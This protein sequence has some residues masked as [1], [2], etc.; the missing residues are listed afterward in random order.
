MET[1][2][3]FKSF[4]GI[5]I[6]YEGVKACHVLPGDT[7]IF[8]PRI[9]C[10]FIYFEDKTQVW[11]SRRALRKKVN[12]INQKFIILNET[13]PKADAEIKATAVRM[14]LET[15]TN[16]CLVS[17]AVFGENGSKK[18]IKLNSLHDLNKLEPNAIKRKFVEDKK[19]RRGESYRVSPEGKKLYM[20]N[21]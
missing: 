5:T 3:F 6:K 11:K 10:K 17:V 16:N 15:R 21:K 14:G 13:L 12:P 8:L 2:K 7:G 4:L 18:F 19:S 1:L 9:I 20:S